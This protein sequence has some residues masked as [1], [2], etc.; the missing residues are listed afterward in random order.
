M[1]PRAAIPTALFILT[2]AGV[3]TGAAAQYSLGTG[4]AHD[5]NLATGGSGQN[6]PRAVQNFNA[7]NAVV[8]GDV[9]GGR[10]FRGSV[11]YTSPF[12][13]R[14]AVGSDA[15][16]PFRAD[17]ALSSLP[18]VVRG[19]TNS[20]FSQATTFAPITYE[21]D[22]T[23][24]NPIP[25]ETRL[26]RQRDPID[27]RTMIERGAVSGNSSRMVQQ[28]WGGS[29]VGNVQDSTGKSFA[30][31]GSSV[32]GLRYE[33]RSM[34]Q[35]QSLEVG[36]YDR[37]R[38]VEDDVAGR[39]GPVLPGTPFPR[40]GQFDQ[41][42]DGT[43]GTSGS[44]PGAAANPAT[45]ATP[46]A[47][48]S[49]DRVD[50]TVPG[51]A[52][53]AAAGTPGSPIGLGSA[54]IG[55]RIDKRVDLRVGTP[56]YD[57]IVRDLLERYKNDPNVRFNADSNVQL[58]L[59]DELDRLRDELSGRSGIGPG[60]RN[61]ILDPATS[62]GGTRLDEAGNVAPG[63]AT[64]GATSPSSGTG[65]F[66][67]SGT[68][69]FAPDPAVPATGA[70]GA[71]TGPDGKPVSGA[72]GTERPVAGDG[73]AE[74][75]AAPN[76]PLSVDQLAS[77]LRH[78]VTIQDLSPEQR[79]RIDELIARGQT[80]MS[81]GDYFLA[82]QSFERALTMMPG[83]PMAT[84]G[85]IN[86]ELA[87]G[88]HLAAAIRLRRFFADSPEMIAVRYAAKLLPPRER[89]DVAVE[90]IRRRMTVGNDQAEYGLALAYIGR[91]IEDRTLMREGL[92]AVAGTP[93]NDTLR[94]VLKRVWLDE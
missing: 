66:P 32:T 16:F 94:Q 30:V 7:R 9:T 83:H 43:G 36:L 82:E 6:Y 38:I 5:R 12:A 70:R 11:G 3:S 15:I 44:G 1:F 74:G 24:T 61:P 49:P 40:F 64:P 92:D 39:L 45:G 55:E 50:L 75:E 91:Q 63:S 28:S 68:N 88:L 56:D 33:P 73:A 47:A 37:R 65:A 62:P 20:R 10:E 22:T 59:G 81:A 17:S 57:A 72:S 90:S 85:I 27:A 78:N 52:A 51:S 41:S 13:F 54:P 80:Q 19:L 42:G 31:V 21:R 35:M 14:G 76:A 48:V 87:A 53:A 93:A 4:T 26:E 8:T 18:A 34:G 77:L 69:R 2:L 71:Q 46:G 23:P 89:F 60:G 84:A 58:R 86:A 79:S 29:M 25:A 67:S